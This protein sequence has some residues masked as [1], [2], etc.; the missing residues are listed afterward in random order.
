MAVAQ[1]III[2]VGTD[3]CRETND[4]TYSDTTTTIA[5]EQNASNQDVDAGLRFQGINIAQGATI[6][7]VWLYLWR[8][9]TSGT[10]FSARI[11]GI[12]ADNCVAWSSTDRPSQRSKTSADVPYSPTTTEWETSRYYEIDITNIV[13][14]IINRGGWVSGNALAL[15]VKGD[16]STLSYL[17]V[18]DYDGVGTD[19]V[20]VLSVAFTPAITQTRTAKA[21]VD[22]AGAQSID[23]KGNVKTT[24]EKTITARGRVQLQTTQSIEAKTRIEI[25]SPQ[26]LTAKDRITITTSQTITSKGRVEIT[27]SYAI[28]AKGRT[29]K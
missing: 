9:A 20:V 7:K 14:E 11:V 3:D 2:S 23:A 18:Y 6:Q 19:Y 16:G 26:T 29:E 24:F 10:S 12:V 28:S 22:V 4:T 5:V 25:S 1:H 13:Q 8:T 27:S 15:S 17:D 21:R